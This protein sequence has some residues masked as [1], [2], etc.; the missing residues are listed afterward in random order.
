MH[1]ISSSQQN[2]IYSVAL[3][4]YKM[5]YLCRFLK[6]QCFWEILVGLFGRRILC[7]TWAQSW[8]F[9]CFIIDLLFQSEKLMKILKYMLSNSFSCYCTSTEGTFHCLFGKCARFPIF[10]TY[11]WK[12]HH[13]S[14]HVLRAN[15]WQN[16]LITLL[17][18][19]ASNFW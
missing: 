12:Y 16:S 15:N 17:N 1:W 6:S 4:T 3:K 19:I 14:Q 8:S 5:S 2:R 9:V 18:L 10:H 7:A 13:L 11:W